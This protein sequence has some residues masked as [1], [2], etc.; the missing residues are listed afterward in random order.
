MQLFLFGLLVLFNNFVL[1]SA[2]N[3]SSSEVIANGRQNCPA[4]GSPD[5]DIIPFYDSQGGMFST[6]IT[7]I[8]IV[9]VNGGPAIAEFP[10]NLN[11]AFM[12]FT[13]V[14][15]R[16]IS[17]YNC[18]TCYE[19]IRQPNATLLQT[20][21]ELLNGTYNGIEREQLRRTGTS[22]RIDIVA[23]GDQLPFADNSQDF[24]IS[25]HVIEHFYDPIKAIKEWLRVIKPGG[26]VYII[27]PH[28]Q[29][30]FDSGRARTTLGELLHRHEIAKRQRSMI[31][32]I[33]RYGLRMI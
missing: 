10:I 1:G 20:M 18:P 29:R 23:S 26:I 31:I 4:A 9:P 8:S 14:H 24:V 5:Y 27:A 3:S 13:F 7:S 2:Q 15:T 21:V 19:A 17:P 22:A 25:A 11:N 32:D 16:P 28:K 30:T 6:N 12:P 33:T